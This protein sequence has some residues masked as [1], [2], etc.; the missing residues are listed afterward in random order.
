MNS[1]CGTY[2]CDSSEAYLPKAG[3]LTMVLNS[4]GFFRIFS[5]DLSLDDKGDFAYNKAENRAVLTIEGAEDDPM[6]YLI[7][8][9][10]DGFILSLGGASDR[11]VRT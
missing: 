7:T 9:T 3:A 11:W 2:V 6:C 4:N 10:A 1:L 8:V 5:A